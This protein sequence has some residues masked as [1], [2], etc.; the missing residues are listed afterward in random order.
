MIRFA[1]PEWL[2]LLALLPVL[3]WLFDRYRREPAFL[4]SSVQLVKAITSL[5][6]SR[7]GRFLPKLRWLALAFFIAALAR[8]QLRENQPYL[9]M[10]GVDTVVAVGLSTPM[11]SD[12][13]DWDGRQLPRL[14]ALRCALEEYLAWGPRDRVG[15][16]VFGQA[17]YTASPLTTHHAFLLERLTQARALQEE[18]ATGL[19]P[20]LL[21]GLNRLRNE[22]NH[23]KSILVIADDS[24]NRGAPNASQVLG[25]ARAVGATVHA[26]VLDGATPAPAASS[27]AGNLNPLER[28]VRQTGGFYGRATNGTALRAAFKE[29]HQRQAAGRSQLGGNAYRDMVEWAL[30]PGLFLV[31]LEIILTHTVWRKLP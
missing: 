10:S 2:S 12:E 14:L 16:V 1:Q 11:V 31:L 20:A 24:A 30:T 3:A 21:T 26:V 5:T 19:G 9:P 6:G 15:L 8:P 18:Q 23:T 27:P 13:M 22:T 25:A 28:I 7:A 29:I 4:Y 17:A